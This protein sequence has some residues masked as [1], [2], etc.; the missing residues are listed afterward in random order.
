MHDEDPQPRFADSMVLDLPALFDEEVEVF[1]ETDSDAKI[2]IT[3][4]ITESGD[5]VWGG[6]QDYERTIVED[7]AQEAYDHLPENYDELVTGWTPDDDPGDEDPQI[8]DDYV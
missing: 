1:F 3:E 5:S 4:V 8:G 6:L 2:H 7:E